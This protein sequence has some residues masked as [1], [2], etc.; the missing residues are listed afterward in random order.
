[1]HG[2]PNIRFSYLYLFKDDLLTVS[3]TQTVNGSTL[4]GVSLELFAVA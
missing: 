3:L 1:M 2:Q 4:N